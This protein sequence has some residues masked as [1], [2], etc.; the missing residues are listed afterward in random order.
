MG[1]HFQKNISITFYSSRI[2]KVLLF[3]GFQVLE[4]TYGQ[5]I[6]LQLQ[7]MLHKI[8]QACLLLAKQYLCEIHSST[9]SARHQLQ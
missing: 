6:A 1:V 5:S 9:P 7:N 2:N 3:I 4:R 8:Y